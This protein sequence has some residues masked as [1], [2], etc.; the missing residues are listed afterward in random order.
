VPDG[1]D[2]AAVRK[3]LLDEFNMEIGA[4]LGPLAG[5]IWRVGLMG[6]QLVAAPHPA[7]ARRARKRAREAT[8]AGSRAGRMSARSWIPSAAPGAGGGPLTPQATVGAGRYLRR[9]ALA[10]PGVIFAGLAYSYLS[11]P[12][13]RPLKTTNPSSTAFIDLRAREAKAK[14]QAVASRAAV[15]RL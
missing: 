15:G 9:A 3:H 14:G 13:V 11:L 2:E 8:P 5:K 12:D 6:G 10:I 7:V 4:G 1:V